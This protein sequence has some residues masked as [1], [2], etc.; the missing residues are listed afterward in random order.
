MR[1]FPFIA[2]FIWGCDDDNGG[3]ANG[4]GD[5]AA[6]R[7]GL[8]E[9]SF[10]SD[11]PNCGGAETE[12][13]PAVMLIELDGDTYQQTPCLS[14]ENCDVVNFGWN[15]EAK[16]DGSGGYTEILDGSYFESGGGCELS[17]TTVDLS[18]DAQ[19]NATFERQTIKAAVQA[20]AP[21]N[22]ACRGL[23]DDWDRA[24]DRSGCIRWEGAPLAD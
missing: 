16:D 7:T 21:N 14:A 3:N 4:G 1:W 12:F 22:E 6:E 2:L 11:D 20:P 19:G 15:T 18:F 8:Y 13:G 17:Y 24:G 5:A 10:W 23:L 9:V